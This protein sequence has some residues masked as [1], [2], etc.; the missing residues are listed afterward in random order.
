MSVFD[1]C[2]LFDFSHDITRTEKRYIVA[3]RKTYDSTGTYMMLK[4]FRKDNFRDQT[5]DNKNNCNSDGFKFKQ[6]NTLSLA[7]FE[8]LSQSYNSLCEKVR[9]GQS[10]QPIEKEHN[11]KTGGK[12]RYQFAF[13]PETNSINST[14]VAGRPKKKSNKSSESNTVLKMVEAMF[15]RTPEFFRQ[16]QNKFHY[17][18]AEV[19][20]YLILNYYNILQLLYIF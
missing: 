12:R 11:K 7:E 14:Q 16:F 6:R 1:N 20:Q 8:Q 13:S 5:Q 17:S 10:E 4:L 18:S 19:S 15:E 9:T 3:C 2:S